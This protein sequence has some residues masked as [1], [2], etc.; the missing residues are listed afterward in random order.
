[1]RIAEHLI[2]VCGWSLAPANMA[3]LIVQVKKTGLSHVQ[4]A[5]NPLLG[6]PADQLEQALA[7]WNQ[8]GLV[9]TAGM[10]GF[11]GE[12]YSSIA[13]IRETGGIAPDL[14]WPANRQMVLSA[15]QLAARIGLN[16]VTAHLGFIPSSNH[17]QYPVMLERVREMATIFAAHHIDLLSETGQ[18]SA[19]GLLQ[20]LNDLA[21]TNVYVNFDPANM[22]LYGAGNPVQAVGVL[23]RHIAHVHIK[24]ATRSE[25]PGVLWGKEVP[26]GEGHVNAAQFTAA[27]HE[28]HY[29]GPLVIERE[30]GES[31]LPDIATAIAT[32]REV[33]E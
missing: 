31:R 25:Q 17:V 24:D 18:E 23:G 4:L 28:A 12:N 30:A 5:L 32:L 13:A 8:S 20:F 10:I 29:T 26:F 9:A 3:D 6:L 21:C 15:A 27:L 2:G 14:H 33:L 19:A 16:K 7:Q 1:M 11:V 22:I